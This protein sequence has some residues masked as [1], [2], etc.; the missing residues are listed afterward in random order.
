M[1]TYL[2]TNVRNQKSA[3]LPSDSRGQGARECPSTCPQL[4]RPHWRFISQEVTSWAEVGG[5]GV[6]P[7]RDWACLL[8]T[9]TGP[10]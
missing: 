3:Q 4:I 8:P 5:G 2:G 7:H 9:E 6:S 10:L 1:L